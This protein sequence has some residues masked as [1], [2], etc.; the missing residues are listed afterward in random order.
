MG[1]MKKVLVIVLSIVLILMTV[2]ALLMI[3]VM[4]AIRS[5]KTADHQ[6]G[7]RWGRDTVKQWQNGRFELARNPDSYSF[8]SY[9]HTMELYGILRYRDEGS[10]VYFV[11]DEPAYVC[12]DME[13]GT[14]EKHDEI[15]KFGEQD[16]E[17][18][19]NR[20]FVEDSEVKSIGDLFRKIWET[21]SA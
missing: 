1:K 4:I 10:K 3:G 9:D 11:T 21:I 8:E 16:R 19:E 6:E 18:F 5:D 13:Q 2:R 12:V 7:F 20:A 14:Q 17:V 15:G